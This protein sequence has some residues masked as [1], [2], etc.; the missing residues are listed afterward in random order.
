VTPRRLLLGLAAVWLVA[1]SA[2]GGSG[3]D[4]GSQTSTSPAAHFT[5]TLS[6]TDLEPG[7]SFT[8]TYEADPPDEIHLGPTVFLEQDNKTLHV[9]LVRDRS[10]LS[11]LP[12]VVAP[13]EPTPAVT[14]GGPGP[15]RFELPPTLEPGVY[16]LCAPVSGS[17]GV[18]ASER[19]CADFT[20]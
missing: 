7:S 3:G 2:C 20:I 19:V 1:T 16:S 18:R 9:L 11:D 6:S 12:A 10:G 4:Q 17:G 5:M 15:F 13:S 14:M 8:V